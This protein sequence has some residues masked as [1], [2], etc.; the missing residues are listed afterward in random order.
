ML[1]FTVKNAHVLEE[2]LGAYQQTPSI[3]TTMLD[4]IAASTR[5]A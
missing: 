2:L 1:R 5:R 3:I 4:R